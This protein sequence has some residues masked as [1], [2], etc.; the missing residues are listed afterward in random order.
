MNSKN[1]RLL[2]I[3]GLVAIL[4]FWGCGSYGVLMTAQVVVQRD[5]NAAQRMNEW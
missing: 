3:G 4:G 5:S 2:I 1:I